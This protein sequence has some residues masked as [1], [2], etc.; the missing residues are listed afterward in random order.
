MEVLVHPTVDSDVSHL[1]EKV[2]YS[3]LEDLLT[4]IET[5]SSATLLDMTQQDE[6]T[7]DILVTYED[8]ILAYDST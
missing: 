8:W 7:T 3:S 2:S 4:W 1:K 6:F 5:D